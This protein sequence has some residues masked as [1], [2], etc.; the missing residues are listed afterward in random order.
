MRC[1]KCNSLE[2]KVI[3]SRLSKD[4]FSI[5]RRRECLDCGH[6]FTTYEQVERR[7]VLVVK[8]DNTREPFKRE[9]LLSGLVKACEKR[10][11]PIEVLENAVDEI[12]NELTSDNLK[13]IPSR[14]I[15]P[16]VMVRLQK[17][18]PVAFV[19]Y[20]SVYRQFQDVGEFSEVIESLENIP[21]D[22]LLQP[23]LFDAEKN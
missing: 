13:E 7:D 9:K 17:I 6:R 1:I 11:V 10:P 12:V 4:G 18:D 5:R 14:S 2:D 15:G 22:N 19:R 21:M 20:A 3:D 16:L 23:E 8:R